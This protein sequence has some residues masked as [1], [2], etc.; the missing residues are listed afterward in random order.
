MKPVNS[1]KEGCSPISS[2]CVIWQGPDI[3][4]INLCKGDTVTDVVYQLATE[5]CTILDQTNVDVYDLSCLNLLQ[6]DPADFQKLIQLLI[7]KICQLEGVEPSEGGT[8]GGTTGGCP[9]C[10]VSVASCLQETDPITGNPIIREQLVSYVE[11]VGAQ[12]CSILEDIDGIIKDIK[13][14]NSTIVGIQKDI[15]DLEESIPDPLPLVTPV[16]VT[17]D[18]GTPQDMDVVLSALEAE[19]CNLRTVT[20]S[21]TNLLAALTALCNGLGTNLLTGNPIAGFISSPTTVADLLT[22]LALKVCDTNAALVYVLNTCCDTSCS[23]IDLEFDAEFLSPTEI[24]IIYSGSIPGN[25]IDN[26]PASTVQII[27]SD[28]GLTD[29]ITNVKIFDDYYNASLPHDITLA[30]ANGENNCTVKV[31]YDFIDPTAQQ[32]CSSVV[33]KLVLGTLTCP[34]LTLTVFTSAVTVDFT[35]TGPLPQTF[36]INIY[37]DTPLSPL[38]ATTYV[39][40]TTAVQSITLG[41]LTS[42]VGYKL[43]LVIDGNPCEFEN[44]T[45]QTNPA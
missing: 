34:P 35:Y 1:N 31:T 39:V 10:L 42:G 32:T 20:G 44:F 3:E 36:E 18:P 26:N 37:E 38:V 22:N 33:Q 30:Q 14:I 28:T 12:I 16:C 2:N 25:F 9:D 13:D 27:D 11:R 45:T 5:L 6:Q 24:R 43:Q 15:S 19:Y 23:A 41:G 4:C 40:G 7:D 17:N 8:G 29:T 21:D